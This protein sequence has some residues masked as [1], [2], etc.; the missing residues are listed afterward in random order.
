MQVMEAALEQAI[1]VLGV[2]LDREPGGL[3]FRPVISVALLST[4]TYL[5]MFMKLAQNK[6]IFNRDAESSCQAGLAAGSVEDLRYACAE[7]WQ[8]RQGFRKAGKQLSSSSV[9]RDLLR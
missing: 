3:S 1:E 4:V 6:T 9:R 8:G 2:S 7:A 5:A